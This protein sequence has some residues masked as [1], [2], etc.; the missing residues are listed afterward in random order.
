MKKYRKG[1][2]Y[3]LDL[4]RLGVLQPTTPYTLTTDEINLFKKYDGE[5]EFFIK[6][7]I[8]DL[9]DGES[10]VILPIIQIVESEGVLKTT[11]FDG[12]DGQHN[13]YLKILLFENELYVGNRV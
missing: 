11:M 2:S 13:N 7:K 12:V 3:F 6:V 1:G 5:K 4:T 8:T 10:I 9:G